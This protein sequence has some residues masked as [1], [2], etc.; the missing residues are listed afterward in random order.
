[1]SALEKVVVK[2]STNS[3][4]C[5]SSPAR[6]TNYQEIV[7]SQER[8]T[9]PMVNVFTEDYK[10]ERREIRSEYRKLLDKTMDEKDV[11]KMEDLV[12]EIK[13]ANVLFDKI[14]LPRE[15]TFDAA[16]MKQCS[17]VLK[18]K[19]SEL[20][21]GFC[22]DEENFAKRL[23]A[24][25]KNCN[26]ND[27][28]LE[29]DEDQTSI[30]SV[31][32]LTEENWARLDPWIDRCFRTAPRLHYLYGTFKPDPLEGSGENSEKAQPARKERRTTLAKDLST[33]VSTK[34]KEI[35]AGET[36][37]T[38]EQKTARKIQAMFAYLEDAYNQTDEK[39]VSYI[40]FLF[41]P[42]SFEKT[43]ENMFY[44]SFLIKDNKARVF[45]DEKKIPMIEPIITYIG[46]T[47]AET[48]NGDTVARKSHIVSINMEQW[49]RV[50]DTFDIKEPFLD[51]DNI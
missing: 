7:V 41:H 29:N 36:K 27:I 5:D 8:A 40:E 4:R 2:N 31:N 42:T 43:V 23:I 32:L 37:E 44:F 14:Q 13:E 15:G 12:D 19:A 38:D 26:P 39:P 33:L 9:Q 24:Y 50:V 46:D 35:I 1:M 48:T 18:E 20:K 47:L 6:D 10:D 16:L 30:D 3:S 34:P 45:T 22:F 25:M 28:F 17:S 11:L 49:R 51:L 21:T